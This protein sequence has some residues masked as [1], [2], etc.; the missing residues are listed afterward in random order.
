MESMTQSS[1][2]VQYWD[3]ARN[4]ILLV[5]GLVLMFR[6]DPMGATLV[7]LAVPSSGL[8]KPVVAAAPAVQ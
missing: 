4:A 1:P 7:A 8:Q 5:A 6:R 2:I 3:V